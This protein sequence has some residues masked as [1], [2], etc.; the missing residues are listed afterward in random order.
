MNN[1]IYKFAKSKNNSI[2]DCLNLWKF[3]NML[4]EDQRSSL[5]YHQSTEGDVYWYTDETFLI[6]GLF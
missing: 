2:H 3:R 1:F 5:D 4:Y 6:F